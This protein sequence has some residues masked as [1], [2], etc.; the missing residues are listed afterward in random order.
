MVQQY[1]QQLA[2][3]IPLM[4][5]SFKCKTQAHIDTVR[6]HLPQDKSTLLRSL[7]LA[8]LFQSPLHFITFSLVT[9]IFIPPNQFFTA[10]ALN[11][12]HITIT[13]GS[14]LIEG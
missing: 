2:Q 13:D 8:R 7:N 3:T 9:N 1:L 5:L 12:Y 6:L 10:S 11:F 4:W 14:N